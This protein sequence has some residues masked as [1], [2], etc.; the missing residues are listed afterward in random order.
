LPHCVFFSGV[1]NWSC[2]QNLCISLYCP[3]EVK[4]TT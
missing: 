3:S 1:F 2:S 4:W